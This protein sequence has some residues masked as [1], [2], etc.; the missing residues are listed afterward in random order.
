[1]SSQYQHGFPIISKRKIDGLVRKINS[2][3]GIHIDPNIFEA[4]N[5]IVAIHMGIDNPGQGP[6]DPEGESIG[7]RN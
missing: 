2:L 1:M 6:L 3:K 5:G 4:N 7:Y